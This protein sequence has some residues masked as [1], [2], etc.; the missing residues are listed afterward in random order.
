MELGKNLLKEL[1][2][3]KVEPSKFILGQKSNVFLTTKK[4]I[5]DV[6]SQIPPISLIVNKKAQEKLPILPPKRVYY[7]DEKYLS[8]IADFE[9]DFI[10]EIETIPP[11]N[12]EKEKLNSLV[13]FDQVTLTL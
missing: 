10:A 11:F 3:Q 13:V 5:C 6:C 12:L 8:K 4:V 1:I 9:T 2:K 7:T